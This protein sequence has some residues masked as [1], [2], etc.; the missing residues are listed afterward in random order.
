MSSATSPTT[1]SGAGLLFVAIIAPL[2]MLLVAV[3][4]RA[5]A[6]RGGTR[7]GTPAAIPAYALLIAV[8]S[9]GLN[10]AGNQLSRKVEASADRF[11]LELTHDP[12]GFI[13]LQQRLVAANHSDPNPSGALDEVL[14]THPTTVERIGAALAYAKEEGSDPGEPTF[15]PAR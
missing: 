10:L 13:E 14:L 6:E 7:P 12:R 15:P 9:F 3:G 8:V 5:L 4:G 2:G 11:A 1:T